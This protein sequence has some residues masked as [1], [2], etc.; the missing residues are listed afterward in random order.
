MTVNPA[1]RV[2][3]ARIIRTGILDLARANTER[4]VTQRIVYTRDDE[5]AAWYAELRAAQAVR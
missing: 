5:A 1:S 3:P 4:A 2:R